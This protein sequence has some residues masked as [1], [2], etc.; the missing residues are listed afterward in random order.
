VSRA[1]V[2]VAAIAALLGMSTGAQ[3]AQ[4]T[5]VDLAHCAAISAPVARLACYDT[6]AGRAPDRTTAADAA[7]AAPPPSPAPPASP[8]P[9]A[10]RAPAAGAPAAAGSGTSAPPAAPATATNDKQNFGLS[11][12]QL[13]PTPAGPAAIQARIE[14]LI[15]NVGTGRPTVVLEGGQT[16]VFT[17]MLDDPRLGPGDLVTIKRAALGS[18]MMTTPTKHQYHVRRID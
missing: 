13:H 18:F 7:L 9:S 8:A 6:L 5:T 12:Y 4:P 11:A 14:K 3:S 17:E 10:S 2:Y 16:W 1:G 15:G